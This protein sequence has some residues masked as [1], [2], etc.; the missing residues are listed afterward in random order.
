MEQNRGRKIGEEPSSQEAQEREEGNGPRRVGVDEEAQKPSNGDK[1]RK[2]ISWVV[3]AASAVVLV[4]ALVNILDIKG[5][6]FASSNIYSNFK[7]AAAGPSAPAPLDPRDRK[8]DFDALRAL[9]DEV[10]A[11]IYV[12]NTNI[13]YPVVAGEDN[14]YYISHSANRE[15]NRA[16]AIFLDYESDPSFADDHTLIYGHRMNDGSM[17]ADLHKFEDQAFLSQNPEV[18]IYLPDGTVNVY[19]I[20][21]AGVVDEYDEAYTIGFQDDQAYEAYLENMK[22]GDGFVAGTELSAQDRIITLSTCV[23]GQETDRYIVQAV[24][25]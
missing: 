24:L 8:I 16:G 25:E 1:R 6:D 10:C 5:E 23:R 11:W 3:I 4:F 20:F 15:K 22:K 18:F 12:P 21:R 17:F 19:R 14:D 7:Q 2:I 13:D 9:N